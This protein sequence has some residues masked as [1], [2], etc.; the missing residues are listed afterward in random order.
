MIV[1]FPSQ[2]KK[3]D[4][5]CCLAVQG[6]LF[7]DKIPLVILGEEKQLWLFIDEISIKNK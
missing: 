3:G 7:L 1:I 5:I 6:H 4:L 2:K